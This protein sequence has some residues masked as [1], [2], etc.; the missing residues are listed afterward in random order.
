MSSTSE[1][2]RAH[3]HGWSALAAVCVA[4]ILCAHT[5]GA[6]AA[7]RQTVSPAQVAQTIEQVR[8]APPAEG[9]Y[10]QALALGYALLGE[11]R[12]EEAARLF[13]ALVER[14]PSDPRA[15]YGD[16]LATFDAGRAADAEPLARRA[17]EAALGALRAGPVGPRAAAG[18]RAEEKEGKARAADALVLLGVVLAVRGDGAGAL[19]AVGQ[20]VELAPESFDAQLALGRARF[21]AGDDAGAVNA[22][23]AAVAL[24]PSDA[25]ARFFL[26]TALE[27]AGDDAGA[28]AAYRELVALQPASAEGH[29]GLGV[30]LLKRGG[31]GADEGLQE[32]ARA[33]E[34][35]PNLYEARVALG[36]A[37]V[38]RGRAQEAVEHLRRA[39]EL[40]PNNP[41][42]HYQLSIA[43]RRLGRKDEAAAEA[44]IVKRIHESR[45]GTPATPE[46]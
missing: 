32:L 31:A 12:Y 29:M 15:L 33:L 17:V 46:D 27:H 4:V 28:L 11:A 37:L 16:A 9:A 20:A 38:E 1:R 39:A 18:A 23:R 30:L 13:D 5:S 26:A 25:Q 45:R 6:R 34:I 19:K 41:E 2:A 35:N 10:A 24:R 40:A 22:F 44:E 8:R 43:Y 3:K 7:A 42:P 21:G 36:R 14:R